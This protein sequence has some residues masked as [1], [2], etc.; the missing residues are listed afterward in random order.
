MARKINAAFW[1]IW[2]FALCLGLIEAVTYKGFTLKHTGLDPLVIVAATTFL[3]VLLLLLKFK[4]KDFKIRKGEKLV[5]VFF[6]LLLSLYG[7]LKEA[8]H[9][10][11]PNFVFSRLHIQ[12]NNLLLPVLISFLPVTISFSV[13]LTSLLP[14]VVKKVSRINFGKF[15]NVQIVLVLFTFSIIIFN[16]YRIYKMEKSTFR[17]IIT[18]PFASYDGKMRQAVGTVFYNYMQ[19][20]NKYSPENAGLLIPPQAFPWPQSGNGAYLRYFIYP[21]SVGNG[22]EYFPGEGVSLSDYDYVLLAWGETPTTEGTYTHG[23]PKFD[24]PAEKIIFMN[25]D[26]SFGGE[27]KGDYH[28][29]DYKDK[30]VWGL[31]KVKH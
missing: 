20:I 1:I 18:N 29:K 17:F 2:L 7:I 16:F 12:P 10:T 30:E 22:N 25:K 13:M 28:D 27:V 9:L 19:F 4:H 15:F 14:V 5:F 23:W 24:V 3:A 26:G 31:I 6:I 21:R 11:Y 8:N